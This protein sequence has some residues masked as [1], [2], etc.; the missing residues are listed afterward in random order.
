MNTTKRLRRF[1]AAL[2]HTARA[3]LQARPMLRAFAQAAGF[4][5]AG[6]I[7]SLAPLFDR[8]LPLALALVAAPGFGPAAVGAFLGAACGFL[9]FWGF[10]AALELLA[11]GFLILAGACIF[12]DLLPREKRWFTPAC[13]CAL[14]MLPGIVC[15][16]GGR[17][18]AFDVA[19]L[20]AKL[21]LLGTATV[22][23]SAGL[24]QDGRGRQALALALLAGCG[25]IVLPGSLPLSIILA[26]GAVFLSSAEP[27][28]LFCAAACGLVLDITCPQA[29]SMCAMLVFSALVCFGAKMAKKPL[30]AAVFLGCC[31]SFVLFTGGNDAAALAGAA[32]GTLLALPIDARSFAHAQASCAPATGPAAEKL[33]GMADI[34]TYIT[35][36]LDRSAAYEQ[37]PQSAAVFDRAAERVCRSCGKYG[38]CWNAC[39]HETYLA[40]SGASARILRRGCAVRDDLPAFFL[41]RCCHTGGFLSAVNEALDE[42]LCRLQYH[43]RLAE[44]RGILADHYR[45]LAQALHELAAPDEPDAA[46]LPRYTPELGFRARGVRA[47]SVSGDHGCS[48]TCGEWYYV[49]LCD[50]MGTGTEAEHES[51]TAAKLLRSMI[52]S[53][54]DALGA[55]QMLNG[56]YILRQDGGFSTIDLLQVSLVTAEGFLHKWGAPPSYL[57]QDG[58]LIKIGTASP[59][60]GLGAGEAHQAEC[61]KLSLQREQMLV[62]VSDGAA[63]AEAEQYLGRCGSLT[64][65][66]LAAGI[67]DSIEQAQADDQTAVAIRLHPSSAVKKHNTSRKRILSKPHI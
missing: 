20:L 25:R 8:P 18:H 4:C 26:V 19:F 6:L 54:F 23:F 2:T 49:L 1:A 10:A 37:E 52:E 60:P 45:F 44:S 11:G 15:L 48:F 50:G 57:L 43:A 16:L 59:P 40:L 51:R 5:A 22:L 14:Y 3:Q 47:G 42:R 39:A 33:E 58:R 17:V 30:R 64:A 41:E 62:L 29:H 46:Q 28:G 9:L 34:L 21:A 38:V 53:G 56:V 55:M 35:R 24:K 32:I 63:G 65:R 31:T 27:S 36:L 67:L 13:A 61:V 7:L 66:E 12:H